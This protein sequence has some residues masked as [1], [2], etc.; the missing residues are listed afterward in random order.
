MEKSHEILWAKSVDNEIDKDGNGESLYRH[1]INVANNAR[2]ICERLP[3]PADE[4]AKLAEVLVEAGALHDIGKAASGFQKM[5]RVKNWFWGHRHETL[6]TALACVL[7]PNLDETTLFAIL[8]HHKDIPT[9]NNEKGVLPTGELPPDFFYTG[10][11]VEWKEML[12]HL[13]ENWQTFQDFLKDLAQ[14]FSFNWET[15]EITDELLNLG[16]AN[17]WLYR[18]KDGQTRQISKEKRWQASLLRGLLITSDHLASSVDRDKKEHPEI[19]DVPKLIDFEPAIKQKELPT[20]KDLLPYQ[21][22]AS[23]IKGNTILK[24]PTG[25]GKTLA[26]LLWASNNQ[27]EN[28]RFFYVLPFTASINAMAQR[29]NNIFGRNNVGVLHHKNADFLFR[30]ME[31]DEMSLK[32]KNQQAKHLKSLAKEMYHPI[33]ISTPHQILRFAL[34]GRGWETGLAEFVNSCIVYDEVHA[35]EPLITGLTLATA[36]LLQ[37][38]PFNAKILFTSAT[39]PKFLEKLIKE[40]LRIE[41]FHVIE[42]NPTDEKDAAVTNKKRHKIEVREGNLF[43]NLPTIISEI[44]QS[45]QST[46]IFCNHVK[47]S[48]QVYDE[49]KNEYG[50]TDITLLHSRF[51]GRDRTKIETKITQKLS[52]E[53]KAKL[54]EKVKLNSLAIPILVATQAVEVSL[55]IDYERGYS[56]PAPADALGQRL[57]RVNRKGERDA[58]PI[59]IFA[60]PTNG[61]LYDEDLTNKTV[62]LLRNVKGEL[63]EQELTT[64]VDKV[65]EN[66]YSPAAQAEFEKGLNNS[67]IAEFA[68]KIIAGTHIKWTDEIFEKTD[69]QIDVLPQ[70]LLDEYNDLKKQKRY[71][72]ARQLFVPIRWGQYH[73]AQKM[74][75]I[76]KTED[77]REYVVKLAYS[78]DKGLDS[79]KLDDSNFC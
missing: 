65:Y 75:A 48:Q 39:I 3:F 14:A 11:E 53:E 66:G 58:A 63:S 8:T 9:G 18:D 20:G 57:G 72:E 78:E 73:K 24:A 59:V 12:Q 6:S 45:G 4:R 15:V 68:E 76:Y 69:A 29:F 79:D 34:R 22:K 43:E 27:S 19:L 55:D 74:N 28:G 30:L 7:N 49:L 13:R 60:E 77:L 62:E 2:K 51:N 70:T 21:I 47:T 1:S 31:K 36:K 16:I 26:A 38:Q 35:F 40:N 56:E 41:E 33:R 71:I 64:I 23:E 17:D 10:E 54:K 46:L 52:K 50:F 5:L 37:N 67:G 25:A 32:L 42:L 61:H 44:K